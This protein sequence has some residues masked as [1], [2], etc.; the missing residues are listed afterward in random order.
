VR[1]SLTSSSS[2][3]SA[4]DIPFPRLKQG[5][6]Q[7]TRPIQTDVRKCKASV[8]VVNRR[9]P[10]FALTCRVSQPVSTRKRAERYAAAAAFPVFRAPVYPARPPFRLRDHA[11]RRRR[12]A[13]QPPAL[14]PRT[15]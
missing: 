14:A 15:T 12:S 9:T 1:R 7:G 5:R 11:G 3:S 10:E 2:C 8:Y 4:T 6:V 13:P